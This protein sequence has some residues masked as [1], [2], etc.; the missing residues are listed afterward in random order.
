M[1]SAGMK[2]IE[3]IKKDD[4]VLSYDN[5]VGRY[6]EIPVTDTYINETEELIEIKVGD[7]TITCTPEHSFLTTKGWKKS[8]NLTDKDILKT[9]GDDQKIT[10]VIKKK[11]NSKI[12]VYNLNVMSCH[13]YA[14]GK[15]GV[16]VHNK[17]SGSYELDFD[18][19]KNILEKVLRDA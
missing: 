18:N 11:L 7:E 15:I 8:G 14:V 4:T 13:T 5:N 6:E 9:L 10:E 17:C 16:I 19:G 12:K 3:E 1:T 2:R